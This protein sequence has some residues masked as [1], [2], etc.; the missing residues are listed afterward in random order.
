[1]AGGERG[2]G[3]GP[4]GAG[5]WDS[6]NNNDNGTANTVSNRSNPRFVALHCKI[7]TVVCLDTV[8]DSVSI[9]AP[10]GCIWSS[11]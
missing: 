1:M 8:S 5:A 4:S 3:S 10:F 9:R 2:G 6:N 7:T 11:Y